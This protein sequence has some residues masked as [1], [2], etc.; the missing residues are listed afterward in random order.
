MTQTSSLAARARVLV[1]AAELQS[2]LAAGVAPHLLDVR[3]QLTGPREAGRAAYRAGHLPG[4][5]FVDLETVLTG[6]AAR[7]HA[8]AVTPCRTP[9]GWP[10]GWLR[11][12]I[13]TRQPLLVYD[14]PGIFAAGRAWWVLRWAGLDV[15]VL[16]GGI[17]A[18]RA[19]GGA[20]ETGD[21]ELPALEPAALSLGHLRTVD[22]D[23]LA[24]FDGDR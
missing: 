8:W 22:A 2:M 16:D 9:N 12:G 19:A 1:S 11:L 18:W 10:P 13:D 21:A 17:T 20:L 7:T 5:R 23:G 3:W 4:A 15:R 14:E 6:P 24:A